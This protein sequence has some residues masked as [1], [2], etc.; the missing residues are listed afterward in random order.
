[1]KFDTIKFSDFKFVEDQSWM[2]PMFF[3]TINSK[4][5]NWRERDQLKALDR[6][7]RL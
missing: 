7:G 4:P 3:Q 5:K 1:M 2:T 6:I